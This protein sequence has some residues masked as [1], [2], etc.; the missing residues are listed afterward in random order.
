M[1]LLRKLGP[2]LALMVAAIAPESGHAQI[3]FRAAASAG[4]GASTT[5]THVAAGAGSTSNGCPSSVTPSV[6]AGVNGDLLI[7]LVASKDSATLTPSAGWNTLFT[8]NPVAAFKSAIYWRIATGAD[9]LT[10]SKTGSGCNVMHGRI[11]RFRGVDTTNP[12]ESGSPVPAANWS[13]Q[14]ANSITTGTETPT[15]PNSMLIF[16]ALIG[17]NNA[18]NAGSIGFTES[19]DSGTGTGSDVQV[20]LGYRLET[21][22]GIKGPFSVSKGGG[23]DPNHGVL[24]ALRPTGST[25]TI[26]VPAGTTTGDVM[27]AGISM[28]PCSGTSGAAC[29][30]T[31]TPPAGWTLVNSVDQTTGG[32][33]G[34]FGNRLFVYR[35][36]VVG[37][38]PASYT[39][40]FGGTPV[41]AGLAGGI[42]TFSGVDNSNPVVASAGQVTPSAV[43][44][45]APSINTGIV[46]NTMLVSSHTTNSSPAWSA[47]AGMTEA[48]DQPSLTAPNDLG[49]SIEINYEARAAAG[50]TGARA[51][52]WTAPPAADTGATHMLALRPAVTLTHYALSGSA[53][54]VTCDV[55]QVQITAHDATHTAVSPA[56]GTSLN[57]TTSTLTGVWQAGLVSGT[58]GWTPSGTN[59]G[60]ATYVWP[61]GETSFTVRLRQNTP[62]TVNINLLDSGGRTESVTED[63]SIVF[64]DT[65][66]RVTSNGTSTATIGTQLSGK[67]SNVGFGLQTLYLQAIRTDTNTG[68]CVGLIQSQTVT[69]EMAAA[70][71]N[72]TAGTSQVSVMNSSSAM[73]ALGTGA[74]AAGAYT[75]VSLSFDASS[76]APLVVNYPNAGSVSL[77]ARYQLPTPPTGTYVAGSS[78]TFVVRPFGLRI[79]GP[80]SGRTG[81]GS[82]AYARAGQAWP[83]SVTVSAV[84]WEAADDADDDG[85]PDSDAILI[86]NAVTTNFGAETTPATAAVSHTLAEPASGNSGALTTSLSAFT[87]GVASTNASF[88]EVGLINLFAISNS[89][90]GSGQNVRNSMPGGY[91]GVGRFYPDHFF[92]AA[93]STLTNRSAAACAPASSFTYMDEPFRLNF[94][95]QA[96]NSA[97]VITQNYGTT[98]GFAKLVPSTIVQLGFGAL[99]AITN[100]TARLDTAISAPTGTFTAGVATIGAALDMNRAASPDGPFAALRVGI[101]P[102]DSDSVTLRTTDMDMDVVA[103]AGNDHQLIGSSTDIRFGRMRLQNAIGSALLDLPMSLTTQYYNGSGFVTNTADNCTTLLA[104]D[105]RFAFVAGTSLAACETATNPAGNIYFNGGLASASAPP[106]SV[107]APKLVKPGAANN[108]AVDL[109]VNLNGASGNM[110]TAVG[111]PGLSATNAAKPWLQGNWGTTTYDSN[112]QGRFTF[113][114]YKAAEEFIYLREN[115]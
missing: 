92:L 55:S 26:N 3:S 112:P 34:G 40:L 72:P 110:C 67:N 39:W 49:V 81:S 19:F 91:A 100:L 60:A 50:A 114:T 22:A 31:V 79:A 21:T 89:Y 7:A 56:A 102:L 101:A 58:G 113:G 37:A 71:I 84:V 106:A 76:M 61:G 103:P 86:G 80:P 23:S 83:D 62:A 5:I 78:N 108:G 4:V 59:N 96:R 42:L 74:G 8:Q 12:F 90:L 66:F 87:N 41:H 97:G 107:V 43:S 28:R 29:T 6:P 63:L 64:A 109:T 52:S 24:F 33:T 104:S 54:G 88:S 94:T 93:G 68:S 46:T 18:V 11:G 14:N 105:I 75:N 115:Y 47:P 77:F 65:A 95:L 111:G 35:K 27:V 2:V 69:I 32:G 98:N 57:L 51:A 15:S 17:D 44:H 30:L 13:Y 45:S 36:I 85:V 70:R 25:L 73:V 20:V 38:E 10:V 53:T 48:V 16:A 9:A 82:T 1:R 99:S